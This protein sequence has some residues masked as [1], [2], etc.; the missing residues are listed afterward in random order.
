[1]RFMR[2]H[3]IKWVVFFVAML[4]SLNVPPHGLAYADSQGHSWTEGGGEEIYTDEN[5]LSDDGDAEEDEDGEE[6]E[7]G[8][9]EKGIS[10]L[11]V[12]L[13]DGF[14]SLLGLA[15]VSL[16]KIIC[17]RVGSGS[18]DASMFTF[19][20]VNGNP[21]GTIGAIAYT[22]L[23]GC[24]FLWMLYVLMTKL[25]RAM[26]SSGNGQERNNLKEGITTFILSFSLMF[27]APYFL[28]LWLYLRDSMLHLVKTVFLDKMGQDTSLTLIGAFRETAESGRITDAIMFVGAVGITVW[29]LF[30]YIGMALSM[31]LFFAM[32]PFV[33]IQMNMDKTALG[34]WCRNVFSISFTPILDLTLLM[35]PMLFSAFFPASWLIKLILCASIIPA[36]RTVKQFLGMSSPGEGMMSA[37]KAAAAL[38][39]V[40]NMARRT[41]QRV[42]RIGERI[43][44]GRE[45]MGRSQM[46]GELAAAERQSMEQS[47]RNQGYLP[48]AEHQSMEQFMRNQGC[49]PASGLEERGE[50]GLSTKGAKR[51]KPEIAP[52]GQAQA[53]TA[54]DSYGGKAPE[55]AGLGKSRGE[56]ADTL[57]AQKDELQAENDESGTRISRL[58]SR[59]ADLEKVN[60]SLKREDE[61]NGTFGL[62]GKQ[63]AQ[64]NER[65]ADINRDI[66]QEEEKVAGNKERI[67]SINRS[68]ENIG[69][70]SR[71]NS[72]RGG[73]GALDERQQ[74]ILRKHANIDN[75][76]NPEFSGLSHEDK[77]E[78]YKKRARRK[79]K[80]AAGDAVAG[81]VGAVS[82]MAAGAA[83]ASFYGPTMQV[84][85]AD[86]GHAIGS[87]MGGMASAVVTNIHKK[88]S[89]SLS[90]K[91][92]VRYVQQVVS[93]ET[94][95]GDVSSMMGGT[96]PPTPVL[97]SGPSSGLVPSVQ[98]ETVVMAGREPKGGVP[99][100][101]M[102][103]RNIKKVKS[104][105]ASNVGNA[106]QYF[107]SPVGR[108]TINT[109]IMSGIEA[110]RNMQN[111]SGMSG[112]E[113][114]AV[115]MDAVS[116]NIIKSTIP[117]LTKGLGKPMDDT[118]RSIIECAMKQAVERTM[119]VDILA[120]ADSFD[121]FGS[122]F[123]DDGIF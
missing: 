109:D 106:Y 117:H 82:G 53:Q 42:S 115:V 59:R 68:M 7:P 122:M 78:L 67:S 118:T 88:G 5:S 15:G 52:F 36:R 100:G 94:R 66:A 50:Y 108:Q 35:I 54:H 33:C 121:D 113:K 19:E 96:Q 120:M 63:I 23:R 3:R 14:N 32:F 20:L 89:S 10:I 9:I 85:A 21:Y 70:G 46:E 98:G 56:L 45:D 107:S 12:A 105:M 111:Y 11:F 80:A 58:R 26:W 116:S 25:V 93:D 71:K 103:N 72:F 104:V 30:E 44:S 38:R 4:I 47:M 41:G 18:T 60:A 79:F 37:V 1:M 86:A 31:L 102:D 73:D 34:N 40:A 91:P 112:Q 76:E 83:L 87:G 29:F 69:I 51:Q 57:S 92:N 55:E 95:G 13:G 24:M 43:K 74:E 39:S 123:D 8:F 101:S 81:T 90:G 17:G 99:N 65:I 22:I 2:K 49:S 77:A 84:L 75:F 6:D 27:L 61:E 28:D 110:A 62:H 114:R 119:G 97:P 16:D 48:E 64:N